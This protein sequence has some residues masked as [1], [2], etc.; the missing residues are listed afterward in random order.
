MSKKRILIFSLSYHPDV[1]GAEIAIKAITDRIGTSE[2]EFSVITQR[3]NAQTPREERMGNVSVYRVG[4]GSSYLSKIFFIPRAAHK[5]FQLNKK[6]PFDAFWAMMSYMVFP[7]VLLRFRGIRI[8]YAV[9]LQEGDPFEHVFRRLRLAPFLPLLRVGFRHAAVVQAISTFLGA[10][11]RQMGFT[12][13]LEIIPN[14]VDSA[15]FLRE[16]PNNKL[17]PVLNKIH[18]KSGDVF[19]V[20]TSRLV[21]K[22]AVDDIIRA[23]AKLP[24]HIKCVVVGS[25]PE[26]HKLK[27][28]AR[29]HGVSE[30]MYFLG[31]VDYADIPLYLKVSDIFVRPSRSEGMGNSFIEAMAA[32]LPVIA[33]QEGGIADFLFDAKCNPG[34]PPTGFAVDKDAPEQIAEMVTYILTHPDEVK[35]TV[36]NAREFVAEKYDWN[37]I[38]RDM[39]AKIFGRLL[40]A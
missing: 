24:E 20:T 1:G 17:Q 8:P 35:R 37:H 10:W 13:P 12:G 33:T 32:G 21:H 26:E 6:R 25:G 14:G 5:A 15:A 29:A 22:N 36:K 19:L 3:F 9:T 28:F 2:I 38:A 4:S 39:K 34:K 27:S 18:K 30:R 31:H 7:I 40:G 23:L 16:F 11:S